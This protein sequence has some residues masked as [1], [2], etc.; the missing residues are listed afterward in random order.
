VAAGALLG[1]T[2]F[3]IVS[4]YA[5]WVSGDMYP[6]TLGGL[7]TCYAAAIPFYRNDLIS[8]AIVAG[9]A[10]GVPVLVR[11]MSRAHAVPSAS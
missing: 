6:R 1:P 11:R 4:N 8:T 9:L 3:F 7:M 10:F 2:S 5:V